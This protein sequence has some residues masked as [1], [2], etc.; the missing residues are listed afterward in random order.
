MTKLIFI[1]A[2]FGATLIAWG[3][4]FIGREPPRKQ[5][6]VK[7]EIRATLQERW[8]NTPSNV[9]VS[10]PKINTV[11]TIAITREPI[12]TVEVKEVAPQIEEEIKRPHRRT[13]FRP[14]RSE[15]CRAHGMRKVYVGRYKWR[16]R[17]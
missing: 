17:R 1:F 2:G 14:A 4:T 6:I 12:E 8:G 5:P 16:C 13:R 3:I 9:I 11:R 15:I 10:P 7:Q